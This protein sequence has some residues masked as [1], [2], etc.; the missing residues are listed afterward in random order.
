MSIRVSFVCL[1]FFFF[2][3]GEFAEFLFLMFFFY[4]FFFFFFWGGGGGGTCVKF[5]FFKTFSFQI[6]IYVYKTIA[7][8][9]RDVNQNI[10]K[11]KYNFY[12]LLKP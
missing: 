11:I 2:G 9:T 8:E 1:F 5:Y 4:Y 6:K 3:G 10:R 12:D 7:G